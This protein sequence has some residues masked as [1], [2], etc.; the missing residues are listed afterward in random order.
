MKHVCSLILL[1]C[2][3]A[4]L[5]TAQV[6]GRLEFSNKD[7]YE[8]EVVLS[9]EEQG[10]LIQSFAKDSENGKR[11]FKTEYYS[12]DMK[13]LFVD[14]VLIDKDLYYYRSIY[15]QHM[16]YTVLRA[17]DGGFSIVAFDPSTRRTAITDGEYTRKGSIRTLNIFDGLLVFSS[18]RKKLDRIGIIDLKTGESRF[19]DMHFEGVKDRKVFIMENTVI[20]GTIYALVD[21]DGEVYLVR[22]DRNGNQL[23][24]TCL[25]KDTDRKLLSASISEAGGKYFVTGTYTHKGDMAEGIYFSELA[26][27]QFRFVKCYNFLDL[28]NFTEYMSDKRKAKVERRKEKAEKK[29]KE[30]SL[31]YLMASHDIMTDGRNYFYLGEAYYPVYVTY[32]MGNIMQTRFDGYEYTHAVL[33]KFDPEGKI[34]WDNCFPMDTKTRPMYVKRFVSAGFKGDNV[35]LVYADGKYFV[36]KLFANSD[37]SVLQDRNQER[38]ETD[39]EAESVRKAKQT[40]TQH[41]YGENF[42]VYGTQIVKNKENGSRRK[43]FS[44]TKYTIK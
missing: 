41:W 21:V 18:T 5:A 38:L 13:R 1:L 8:D 28:K 26:D 34:L 4:N 30:Y 39:N 6:T 17:R 29:G 22:V 2:M 3:Q 31:K 10:L 36:S 32:M 14:S 40:N 23:G 37:G 12:T 33:A 11:F 16:N 24:A 35:N 15:E 9:M 7:D 20:G 44:V 43:V 19:A 25:T 42:L 27:W